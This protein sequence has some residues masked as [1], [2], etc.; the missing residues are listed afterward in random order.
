MAIFISKSEN[1]VPKHSFVYF[2]I[3]SC[4]VGK[5]F[6]LLQ[7]RTKWRV[8]MGNLKVG[9]LVLVKKEDSPPVQWALG[10]VTTLY[11]MFT[12]SKTVR[13]NNSMTLKQL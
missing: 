1:G 2:F 4:Q 7:T 8:N 9:G 13:S 11:P 5:T 3:T 12:S 10:R 6:L